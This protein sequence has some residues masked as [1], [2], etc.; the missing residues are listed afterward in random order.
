[1][2]RSQFVALLRNENPTTGKRLTARRNT[3]RQE[4]GETV[5]NWQ[6][7][8]GLLFGVP[9]SGIRNWLGVRPALDHGAKS[10]GVPRLRA[11]RNCSK[12]T[13]PLESKEER[14]AFFLLMC[15][16]VLFR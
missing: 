7:G 6:V 2:E 14:E 8:Y 12:A 5:S 9:G 15:A 1:M 4:D 3:S 16:P 10:K 13:P 11:Y